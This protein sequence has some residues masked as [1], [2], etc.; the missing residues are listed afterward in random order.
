MDW[1]VTWWQTQE[2]FSR[3][4]EENLWR[5]WTS[6]G[7]FP[8]RKDHLILSWLAIWHQRDRIKATWAPWVHDEK[9]LLLHFDRMSLRMTQPCSN[10]SSQI[11]QIWMTCL[12]GT[13]EKYPSP[14][15]HPRLVSRLRV[16]AP[17]EC[18][19][20]TAQTC[21]QLYLHLWFWWFQNKVIKCRNDKENNSR[22]ES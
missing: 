2:R 3:I 10:N 8:W 21:W 6:R 17:S 14:W 15:M 9:R 5:S 4:K 12:L 16:L 18:F 7:A 11:R 22:I 20:T 13:N 1:R 19:W